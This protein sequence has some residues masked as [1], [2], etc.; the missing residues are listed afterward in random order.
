L[1]STRVLCALRVRVKGRSNFH[2]QLPAAKRVAAVL[3]VALSVRERRGGT[4]RVILVED[5]ENTLVVI[6]R[7]LSKR[8]DLVTTAETVQQ[9]HEA[10]GIEVDFIVSNL[11]LPDVVACS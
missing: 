2:F 7:L 6:S 9:A 1:P 11:S 8:G 3:A 4:S 10:T 5:R